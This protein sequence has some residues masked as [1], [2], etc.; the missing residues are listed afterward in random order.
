VISS[1][2]SSSRILL[3][4]C[5]ALLL[6]W[7]CAATKEV[8]RNETPPSGPR[9][10]I[11]VFP[12]ENLSG[13]TAPVKPIRGLLIE[14]LKR[15]GFNVLDDEVLEGFLVR[16]RIRYTGGIDALTA[17]ALKQETGVEAVFIT[18]L[19][20]FSDAVPPKIALTARL[21]SAEE[22]PSIV[23]MD[24]VGLA[25]DDSPGILALGLI[26]DTEKLVTKALDTLTWSCADQVYYNIERAEAGKLQSKFRPKVSYRSPGLERGKKPRVAVLPFFNKSGRKYGGEIMVLNLMRALKYAGL[27]VVEPGVVRSAFLN[28]RIIMEDGI[29]LTEANALFPVVNADFVLGGRVFDYEDYEGA[30]GKARVSFSVQ[31]INKES[32]KVAWSSVSQN[33]GDDKVY[34]FDWGRVNTAHAMASQMARFV[35]DMMVTK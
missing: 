22:N 18:S 31:L 8:S 5:A 27:D 4:L 14:Q 28:L 9:V 3:L 6:V 26:E 1:T 16:N 13:T 2:N 19:E 29:A 32:Q 12:V 34:F 15:K 11:A 20:L 25:G 30:S 7:G 35:G 33:D 10:S 23:W 21:V 17:R 24:G